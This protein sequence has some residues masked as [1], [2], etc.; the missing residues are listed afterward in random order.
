MATK[1]HS[2]LKPFVKGDP[3]CNRKG[4]P[5]KADRLD[6]AFE[7]VVNDDDLKQII[8]EVLKKARSGDVKATEML[9]DRYFGKPIA[10]NAMT[11]TEGNDVEPNAQPVIVIGDS[12]KIIKGIDGLN[13]PVE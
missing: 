13:D 11:D 12:K 5:K 10:R 3:R 2:Q 4:R 8:R 1:D 7:A 6:A 9:L